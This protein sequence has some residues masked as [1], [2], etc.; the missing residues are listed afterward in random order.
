MYLH[1]GEV[2]GLALGADGHEG[3]AG[4]SLDGVLELLVEKARPEILLLVHGFHGE[5]PAPA[6][7][8]GQLPADDGRNALEHRQV[9]LGELHVPGQSLQGPHHLLGGGRQGAQLILGRGQLVRKPRQHQPL[10]GHLR[11]HPLEGVDDFAVLPGEDDVA[12][13]AHHLHGQGEGDVVAQLV[14]G[15]EVK[16]EQALQLRLADGNQ[17]CPQ[18][19][20]AQQHAQH[21]RL[22]G[23]LQGDG[24]KVHPGRVGPGGE[25]HAIGSLPGAEGHHQLLPVGLVDFIHPGPQEAALQFLF[26]MPQKRAVQCHKY[27]CPFSDMCYRAPMGAASAWESKKAVSGTRLRR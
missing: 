2:H 3:L 21:G 19:L 5:L 25:Q 4:D 11:V 17:F 13:P 20:F 10:G 9:A 14:D 12:V 26:D 8:V 22:L 24:G 27:G 23:V 7:L 6:H 15:V 16:V 1:K 18:Q